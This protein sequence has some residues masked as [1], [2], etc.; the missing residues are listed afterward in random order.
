MPTIVE[1]KGEFKYAF[2]LRS[3][4]HYDNLTGTTI[5]PGGVIYTNENLK[6][7]DRGRWELIQ[8]SG[9]ESIDELKARI[10][11]LEGRI[12]AEAAP[13]APKAVDPDDLDGKSIKDLRAL[14]AEMDPPVDLTDCTGKAEI[15]AAIRQAIDAA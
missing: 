6:K 15:V 9:Q 1:K 5:E 13:E 10:R 11:I 3:G 2:R 7:T 4:S 12:A 14:A 8:E